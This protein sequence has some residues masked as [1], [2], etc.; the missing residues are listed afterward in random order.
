MTLRRARLTAAKMLTPTV[1]ELTFLPS[2]PLR[3]TPGQWVS[4]RLAVPDGEFVQRAYSIASAPRDDGAFD[5]AVTHVL[6]GP[7][8]TALH[9]LEL[10]QEIEHSHAQGFFTLESM[11]RPILFVGTGTGVTPLRSMLYHALSQSESTHPITLVLGVRTESDLL[12]GESLLQLAAQSSG[13]FR[14]VST[15]SRP[16]AGWVGKSGY[17]QTHLRAIVEEH[18]ADLDV[19]VCGLQKMIKDVR[20]LLRNELGLPRERVHSERFD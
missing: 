2:E 20:F 15:L 17:V 6:G 10:G 16:G 9:A 8:S 18:A 14:F 7:A 11:D 4:V 12:Y 3:F 19:Y 5:L 1:R 13:R